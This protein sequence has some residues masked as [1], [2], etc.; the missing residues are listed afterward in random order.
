MSYDYTR[1]RTLAGAAA[2]AVRIARAHTKQLDE[3]FPTGAPGRVDTPS[4]VESVTPVLWASYLGH[5]IG[6]LT[7][8][9]GK[10]ATTAVL[11]QVLRAHIGEENREH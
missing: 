11:R 9:L 3:V 5:L 4:P 6:H 8:I 7:S 1:E 10:D 2:L